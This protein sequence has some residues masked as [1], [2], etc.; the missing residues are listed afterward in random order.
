MKRAKSKPEPDAPE[1]DAAAFAGGM[2]LADAPAQVRDSI[3]DFQRRHRGTQKTP[4]K[5]QVT[6]RLSRGV[7]DRYRATGRGWQAR[8]DADLTKAAKRL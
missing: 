5:A 6:L 8:I 3:R 1:M 4:T 7:L 2:A